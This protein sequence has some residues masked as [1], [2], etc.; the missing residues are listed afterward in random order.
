M[1]EPRPNDTREML[2]AVY[3]HPYFV[4]VW[5]D[6]ETVDRF[7]FVSDDGSESY[8][9]LGLV[10]AHEW[11]VNHPFSTSFPDAAMIHRLKRREAG[12]PTPS[13]LRSPT[14]EQDRAISIMQN[15]PFEW[16]VSDGRADVH[17]EQ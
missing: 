3:N 13:T 12:R 10:A 9:A 6:R 7:L 1:E 15:H 8:N 4:R 16:E 2:W 5:E 11:V 14:S 17:L